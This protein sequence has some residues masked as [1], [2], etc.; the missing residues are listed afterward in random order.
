MA[1]VFKVLAQGL[2]EVQPFAAAGLLAAG[3][4]VVFVQT[5]LADCPVPQVVL[6]DTRK[7]VGWLAVSSSR[8]RACLQGCLRLGQLQWRLR[9]VRAVWT[10]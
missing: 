2:A 3:A 9:V 8:A 4:T 6:G 10:W 7:A 1:A 5:P